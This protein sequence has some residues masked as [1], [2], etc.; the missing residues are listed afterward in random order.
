MHPHG[1]LFLLIAHDKPEDGA[2]DGSKVG[3][4]KDV[5]RKRECVWAA[6]GSSQYT[7]RVQASRPSGDHSHYAERM[8]K[9]KNL[10]YEFLC[11]VTTGLANELLDLQIESVNYVISLVFDAGRCSCLPI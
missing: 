8:E 4:V 3:K 5:L 7:C 11:Y 6:H 9:V 10:F 1:R 2:T